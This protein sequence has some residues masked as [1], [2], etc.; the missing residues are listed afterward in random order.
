MHNLCLIFV[1]F[2]C[3]EIMKAQETIDYHIKLSWHGIV[4]LYNQIAIQYELTQATGFVLINIDEINGTAATKIAPLMGMKAT[5]LS[6]I[7][8]KMETEGL[9]C[10]KK[11]KG[12]GR[13]VNI[14]LTE[15]GVQKKRI[16]KKVVRE[17]NEFILEKIEPKKLNAYYEVMQDV[18]SLTEIYKN[19]K[20]S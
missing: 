4:N 10:R 11:V 7:L 20:F 9:I 5:S 1:K 18:V 14:H 13:L 19:K 6:R 12:D 16:A 17:F 15:K 8:K 2:V 3:I